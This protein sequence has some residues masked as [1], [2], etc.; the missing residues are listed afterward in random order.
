[1]VAV[2]FL[3]SFVTDFRVAN[4]GDGWL[5]GGAKSLLMVVVGLLVSNALLVLSFWLAVLTLLA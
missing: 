5:A 4:Y 2:F 3:L 1:M